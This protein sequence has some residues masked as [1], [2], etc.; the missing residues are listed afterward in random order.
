MFDRPSRGVWRDSDVPLTP[1]REWDR[2]AR[3]GVLAGLHRDSG[4]ARR[5]PG[6]WWH[7]EGDNVGGPLPLQR[8]P[9]AAVRPLEL[10]RGQTNKK[11]Q[12]VRNRSFD[13]SGLQIGTI[14][15]LIE[16]SNRGL[17]KLSR[18][19]F[20]CLL[21]DGNLVVMSLGHSHDPRQTPP[22][23]LRQDVTGVLAT[24]GGL[25]IRP[26]V[27]RSIHGPITGTRLSVHQPLVA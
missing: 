10:E 16:T 23:L 18:A 6:R 3:I 25:R 11:P 27:S 15:G 4:R 7:P 17:R 22:A 24:L 26:R 2:M 5:P 13:P 9:I 1:G 19:I 12:Q 8:L 20:T 21:A 14:P